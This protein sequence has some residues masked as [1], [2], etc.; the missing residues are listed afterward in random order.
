M[1]LFIKYDTKNN[2]Q[3]QQNLVNIYLKYFYC[4][5]YFLN[6]KCL[7]VIVKNMA[8]NIYK[9]EKR[10]VEIILSECQLLGRSLWRRPITFLPPLYV[11]Q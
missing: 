5:L 9:Q 10:Y 1:K 3:F 7:N 4:W 2:L 6:V 8:S 11:S